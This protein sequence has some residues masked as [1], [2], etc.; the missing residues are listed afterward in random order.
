MDPLSGVAPTGGTQQ[1]NAANQSA[2]A[3]QAAVEEELFALVLTGLVI[4]AAISSGGQSLQSIKQ[5]DTS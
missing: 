3:Q 5:A 1:S 4:P 2:S